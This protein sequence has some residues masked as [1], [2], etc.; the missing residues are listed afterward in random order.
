M[1]NFV[2]FKHKGILINCTN[3]YKIGTNN[4][5]INFDVQEHSFGDGS[6][7]SI[8]KAVR[9]AWKIKKERASQYRYV[10][11]MVDGKICD[12]FK[13]DEWLDA[14][15]ENFPEFAEEF[16]KQELLGRIGFVGKLADYE[17]RLAYI[18]KEVPQ[19]YRGQAPC[20]YIDPATGENE[21]VAE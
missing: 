1:S 3:S 14:T 21:E 12:V 4:A 5:E 8:Y 11:A 7:D 10:F 9:F 19:D 15:P 20:R 13:V 17:L 6:R 2:E 18:G 16:E